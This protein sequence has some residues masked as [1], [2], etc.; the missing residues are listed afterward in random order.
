MEEE[1]RLQLCGR[2]VLTI[3]GHRVE[4][5]LP[6]RQGRLLFVYL[7][8]NRLRPISR[9]ELFE[10]IWPAQLPA[11]PDSALAALLSK[12]RHLLGRDLVPQRGE[13][14]LVLPPGSFVDLE[15]AAEGIHRAESAVR[16]SAWAE[17][18][19]PARVALH[20]ATRGF[21]PGEDAPWVAE[22]RRFLEE[23]AVRAHECIAASSLAL[24][25]AELDSAKR[26]ASVLIECMPYRESG[27]RLMME[28]LHCEGNDAEALAVYERLRHILHDALGALPSAS[29]R[30]LHSRLLATAG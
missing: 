11:A 14:R 26:S 4:G 18:W 21:L 17:A 29:T 7:A 27:Y 13:I 2:L 5:R 30:E 19:A 25:G 3:R 10:A 15:A 12:L 6:S 23:I 16:R 22:R 1:T 8:A 28:T 24:G 20:T 9:D